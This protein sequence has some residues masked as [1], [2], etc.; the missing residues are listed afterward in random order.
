MEILRAI[1][2][3]SN[4]D[5]RI[6]AALLQSLKVLKG[7]LRSALETYIF[8]ELD[9]GTNVQRLIGFLFYCEDTKK[10]TSTGGGDNISVI[11]DLTE[12]EEYGYPIAC[13]DT[14]IYINDI[15]IR[16]DNTET[17]ETKLQDYDAFGSPFN[18]KRLKK[19]PMPNVKLPEFTV[20]LRT[21]Y[22]E[23]HCQKRYREI[24]AGSF[25]IA[26]ENR[27]FTKQALEWIASSEHEDITWKRADRNE[28][29]FIYPTQFT[30][31]PIPFASLL[32][33][34]SGAEGQFARARF[35]KCVKDFIDVF[36]GLTPQNQPE[37]IRVF[38]IR[39]MDNA[40]SKVILNRNCCVQ[41]LINAAEIWQN[42]C[43]NVPDIT[44]LTKAIPFPLEMARILNTS[45]SR[46]GNKIALR[47]TDVKRIK[48]YEGIELL[49]E[50]EN[51]PIKDSG[52][53]YLHTLLFNSKAL[54]K[55]AGNCLHHDESLTPYHAI[56]ISNIVA[57]FGLLLY[58]YGYKKEVYMQN[59]AY[60]IGQMLK[61]TDELHALYCK[62]ERNGSI[63]S[64]L[65]GN[66]MF[67]IALETPLKALSLLSQRISPYICWAKRYRILEESKNGVNNKLV[68]WYL[69]IF[70]DIANSLT[71]IVDE[72][73]QFN[74]FDQAQLFLGYL[75][76]F[77]MKKEDVQDEDTNNTL[78]KEE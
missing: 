41:S 49:L 28:I 56:S 58:K 37:H 76:A 2:T 59:T 33:P 54:L 50:L 36:N 53:D 27:K 23:Q 74:E 29:V 75:A 46:D 51:H 3:N 52:Y 48:P 4:N 43:L 26:E 62:V 15:L 69:R 71:P 1:E 60:L 68:G 64:Q 31:I 9:K 21:M 55:Y 18:S 57:M 11:L 35:D 77:P 10:T 38:Y 24:D 45:W 13:E 78:C 34:S 14:T 8:S 6:I 72:T 70:E 65:V 47:K 66:S 20:T 63:S 7:G 32:A 25:P 5:G 73:I 22:H 30:S 12:W 40:R 16:A 19:T 17:P 61:A 67:T 44:Y 39:K 42:G